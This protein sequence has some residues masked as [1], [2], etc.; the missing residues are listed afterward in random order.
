MKKLKNE[1]GA[2]TILVLV[3]ML[4]LL[5]FLMS[6]YMI[7]SNRAKKQKEISN[8]IEQLYSQPENL[9]DIYNSYFNKEVIPIYTV[10]QLL[11]IGSNEYLIINNKYCKMNWSSTYALMADLTL[12]KEQ[13]IS[14][15]DSRFTG[16]FEWNGHT[17]TVTNSLGEETVYFSESF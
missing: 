4:F 6:A 16:S 8:E 14:M 7:V 17:I 2:I 3:T 12:N 1:K 13:Q 11:K 10:E 5:A 9:I 15:K